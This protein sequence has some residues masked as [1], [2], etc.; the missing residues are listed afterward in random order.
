MQAVVRP[1]TGLLLLTLVSRPAIADDE[2]G[3]RAVQALEA[4]GNSDA[5]QAVLALALDPNTESWL[6]AE[7]LCL[8]GHGA[9][10]ANLVRLLPQDQAVQALS[11]YL[12]QRQP[13]TE[14]LGARGALR[15][16]TAHWMG[17]EY[18]Q[19]LRSVIGVQPSARSVLAVE[20]AGVR[21]KSLRALGRVEAS[22]KAA[23][24]AVWAAAAIGWRS[25]RDSSLRWL[26]HH[27][28]GQPGPDDPVLT[29][30]RR[31]MRPDDTA[32]I[33]G[34]A[35]SSVFAVVIQGDDVSLR[36][37]CRE[38]A[39]RE[40][41]GAWK[42]IAPDSPPADIGS[43]RAMLVGPLELSA[44]RFLVVPHPSMGD[45]PL[46][47]LLPTEAEIVYAPT[48]DFFAGAAGRAGGET[49]GVGRGILAVHGL[50]EDGRT[51]AE[52]RSVGDVVLCGPTEAELEDALVRRDR[53]R[54]VHFACPHRVLQDELPVLMLN[55]AKDTALIP[56]WI[57]VSRW[58]ADLVVLSASRTGVMV[59][60]DRAGVFGW[61]QWSLSSNVP[62]MVVNIW[63][64]DGEATCVLMKK[65]YAL[66]S[67]AKGR[68]SVAT[69]LGQAQQSVRSVPR[70]RHP[71][72]WA[73]WQ[74]WGRPD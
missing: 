40:L 44:K 15:Q 23:L 12:V 43:A 62:R 16:A 66:W 59:P 21:A 47:L 8:T 22:E 49:V 18:E 50:G 58:R 19:A 64:V 17:N 72:Y 65:F 70:W 32:V 4:L 48:A 52:A 14:D 31:W 26:M 5:S 28:P 13:T 61:P 29:A 56:P 42:S 25:R 46:C 55:A 63:D 45:I 6:L 54:A 73:G 3:A 24:E 53:W 68:M 69:A 36:P 38:P 20:I 67:D 10:A 39:L 27:C 11:T 34:V 9:E 7:E 30:L 71:Y 51:D 74:A 2:V 1:G 33:Y 41:C 57:G 37:L 35:H 60:R